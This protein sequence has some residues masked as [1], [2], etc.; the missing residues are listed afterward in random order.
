MAQ[1]ESLWDGP[2]TEL[3]LGIE[4]LAEVGGHHC[5]RRR[6]ASAVGDCFKTVEI[7]PDPARLGCGYKAT[8]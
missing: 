5:S 2:S 4:T 6:D 7:A 1:H 3:V 8:S